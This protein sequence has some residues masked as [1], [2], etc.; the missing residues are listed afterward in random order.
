MNLL[1][2]LTAFGHFLMFFSLAAALVLELALIS[3]SLTVDSAKRIQRADRAVAIAAAL[4]LAFGLA[5]VFFFDKGSAYYFAN[6]F[7]WIKIG[8]F[9]AAGAVSRYPTKQFLSWSSELGQGIAPDLTG[10]T[11]KRLKRAIHWELVLIGGILI[12]ASL[13]AKGFGA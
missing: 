8:L 2:A 6:T 9:V 5:R 10:D 13:M 7:F 11:I 3:Q 1:A 12:C 4:L